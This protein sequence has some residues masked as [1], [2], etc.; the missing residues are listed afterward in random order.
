MT[1][2]EAYV[3]AVNIVDEILGYPDYKEEEDNPRFKLA[4]AFINKLEKLEKGA[5][6]YGWNAHSSFVKMD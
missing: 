4:N 3:Q 5:Q 6:K 1:I 2:K